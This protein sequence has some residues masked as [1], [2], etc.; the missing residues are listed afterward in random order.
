[1]SAPINKGHNAAP[2]TY[3]NSGEKRQKKKKTKKKTRK[4][5]RK[6]NGDIRNKTWSIQTGFGLVVTILLSYLS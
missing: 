2:G 4:K 3:K 6:Q 1:M 5:N